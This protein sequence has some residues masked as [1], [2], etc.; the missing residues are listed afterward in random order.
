MEA[1]KSPKCAF[2]G[3]IGTYSHQAALFF[4]SSS[5]LIPVATIKEIASSTAENIIL[6]LENSTFG[7]V[8]QTLDSLPLT[9]APIKTA[10]VIPIKHCL[11]SS[12][13]A[14]ITKIY[15]HPEALGQCQEFLEK[16]YRDVELVPVQS[17]AHGAL[18]ASEDQG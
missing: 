4:F 14:K 5:E 2:L 1:S 7:S 3:P 16:F 13:S 6:P 18:L 15:S 9:T 11:L 12:S 8:G 17:T 10:V